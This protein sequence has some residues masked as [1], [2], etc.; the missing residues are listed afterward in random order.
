MRQLAV[1]AALTLMA[2]VILLVALKA[3]AI[4]T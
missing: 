3:Q 1:P 4:A 2:L